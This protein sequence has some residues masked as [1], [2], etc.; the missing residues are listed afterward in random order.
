[1]SNTND[2]RAKNESNPDFGKNRYLFA[3]A[4]AALTGVAGAAIA[5]GAGALV[6]VLLG[7]LLGYNLLKRL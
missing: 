2:N 5:G 6:G 1:M 4:G 3:G 7:G